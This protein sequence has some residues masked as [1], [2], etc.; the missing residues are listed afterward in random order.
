MRTIL[1]LTTGGTI[2]SRQTEDGLVPGDIRTALFDKLA[3]LAGACEV[4]IETVFTKDSSNIVPSDWEQL[5]QA[6]RNGLPDYDGIVVLHGTDTMSYSAA[7]L[8]YLFIGV[9]KPIVL[10]GSQLPMEQA[11]SDGPTNLIDAVITASDPRLAGVFVVFHDKIMNGTRTYKRSSVDLDAYISCNYPYVGVIKDQRVYLTEEYANLHQPLSESAKRLLE[12]MKSH[13]EE[14]QNR[15]IQIFL[16]KMTPGFHAGLLDY[17]EQEQYQGIVIE[18]FGLGGIPVADKALT[19][20]LTALIRK[21][22]PVVMAT[23]C[24][25][26][27]VNLHTYE[28]GVLANRLGM[29]SAYDMTSEAVYT[30]LMWIL[31]MTGEPE[32]VREALETDF[33]GEISRL[34]ALEQRKE[35]S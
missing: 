12:R 1:M 31:S 8:S 17:L 35:K 32:L 25:Y 10:T 30:K 2:A 18:G 34:P 13:S 22:I 6:I 14:E 27:G 3:V 16:L 23:Q 5:A 7:M 21:G 19:D 24:V 9:E 15:K 28:V 4:T 11:E 26:D 29:I 33:C 20:K